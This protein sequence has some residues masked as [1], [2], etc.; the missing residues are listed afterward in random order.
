MPREYT[1]E[2]REAQRARVRI[3]Y[4][5]NKQ[6]Y[7]EKA[8]RQGEANKKRLQEYKE[9]LPC[10]DCGVYYPYYVTQFDH[11]GNNKEFDIGRK[12][13]S[14]W[15]VLEREIAKCDLVCANCHAERTHQRRIADD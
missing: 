4:Q 1:P 7:I 6:Y 14:S 8:K 11:T 15:A 9:S 10:T 3:H 5:E 2:Q 13:K 12:G